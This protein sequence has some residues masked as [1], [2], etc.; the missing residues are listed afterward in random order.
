MFE[1]ILKLTFSDVLD[2]QLSGVPLQVSKHKTKYTDSK[3]ET[4]QIIFLKM[5]NICLLNVIWTCHIDEYIVD[6]DQIIR[7]HLIWVNTVF[8]RELRMLK[9]V[10]FFLFLNVKSI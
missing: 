5:I 2:K 1:K 10:L 4:I 8:K 7:S 3:K 9:N 6:P